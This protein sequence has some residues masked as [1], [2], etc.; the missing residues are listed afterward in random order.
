[1]VTTMTTMAAMTMATMAALTTTATATAPR[2]PPGPWSRS[3]RAAAAAHAT[4]GSRPADRRTACA[5]HRLLLLRLLLLAVPAKGRGADIVRPASS[6]GMAAK[7]REPAAPATAGTGADARATSGAAGKT[8]GLGAS[9]PA[10]AGDAASGK[11]ATATAT[12]ASSAVPAPKPKGARGP[13]ALQR[14]P[15]CGRTHV[16]VGRPDSEEAGPGIG[17]RGR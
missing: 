12:T 11:A 4:A 8:K 2:C 17:C 14:R 10:K 6:R 3:A 7:A 9:G 15:H 1:M 13:C 16:R 5:M